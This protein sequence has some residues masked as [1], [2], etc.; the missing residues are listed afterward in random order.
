[1][2]ISWRGFLELPLELRQQIYET[3]F[4]LNPEPGLLCVNRLIH[5]EAMH[6]LRKWQQTFSFHISGNGAGFDEF[7]QWCFKVKRHVPRLRRMKHIIL[8]IHPPD[9][10]RPI[11][12]WHIWNH[13][14]NFC[15]DIIS[16]RRI[17]ALTVNF[18][19]S[20]K[21]KWATKGVAHFTMDLPYKAPNFCYS[22]VGQILAIFCRFVN[23][24]EKPMIV[25]SNSFIDTFSSVT[26]ARLEAEQVEQLMTDHWTEQDWEDEF[27]L[28]DYQIEH[29]DFFCK[30]ATGRKSKAAFE[31]VFG[32]VVVLD[33]EEFEKIKV[34][35]PYME[36]L[37]DWER[38][39]CRQ[40][41]PPILNCVCGKSLVEVT[42]P[43]PAW[44]LLND[45]GPVTQ[46]Q[47]E[48]VEMEDG[49]RCAAIRLRLYTPELEKQPRWCYGEELRRRLIAQWEASGC[50][51]KIRGEKRKR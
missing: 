11:Q 1:M 39:R 14:K 18:V 13:V 51:G 37:D 36:T 38:P 9:P 44:R 34:L 33:H 3:C 16:H 20:D 7:S 49:P 35:W 8:N 28:L 2:E 48:K 5:D 26:M 22:D 27:W 17:P 29:A 25:F 40:A 41:C 24:V 30:R 47:K 21:M 43:D 31:K 45:W 46:W 15:E 19:E 6:F 10:D 42:M 50:K 12:M 23:N 32:Q 4:D